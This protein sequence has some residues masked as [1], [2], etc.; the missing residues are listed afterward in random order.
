MPTEAVEGLLLHFWPDIP[1]ELTAHS[2]GFFP[3]ASVTASGQ[4]L[5]G[6]VINL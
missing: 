4:Q 3:F 1:V 5:T 2:V 6:G